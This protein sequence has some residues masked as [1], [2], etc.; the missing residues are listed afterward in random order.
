MEEEPVYVNAKQ[1]HCILRRRAQ[2]AK[3][4]AEN[5]L[6]KARKVA[7]LQMLCLQTDHKQ[8]QV[9]FGSFCVTAELPVQRQRCT[10]Y[11]RLLC[12]TCFWVAENGAV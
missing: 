2:R 8:H 9:H 10:S 6:I 12:H 5:K 7:P 1:Y 11:L 4:E 3:A